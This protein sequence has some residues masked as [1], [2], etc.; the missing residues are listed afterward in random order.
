MKDP[1]TLTNDLQQEISLPVTSPALL[2]KLLREGVLR[3]LE[4]QTSLAL[5][6]SDRLCFDVM[7]SA[8]RSSKFDKIQR[9]SVKA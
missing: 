5:R 1:F 2:K 9:G 3:S 8:T 6:S 4:R 7:V